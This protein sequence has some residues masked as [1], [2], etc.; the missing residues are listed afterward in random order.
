M[1]VCV[2]V[3]V[4]AHVCVCTCVWEGE[5]VSGKEDGSQVGKGGERMEMG[6]GNRQEEKGKEHQ[7]VKIFLAY[8]YTP[9]SCT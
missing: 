4:C 8:S 5:V 2:C 3:C 1:C 7:F 9:K 6:K